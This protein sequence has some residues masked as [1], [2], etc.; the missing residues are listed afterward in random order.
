MNRKIIISLALIISAAL[1][2]HFELLIEKRFIS[3]L[4]TVF[5][6]F[7]GFYLTSFA[8]FSTSKYLSKL[9]EIEDKNDNRMT[10][11]DRVIEKFKWPT[12]FL[13]FSFVYLILVY[14]IL[15]NEVISFVYYLSYAL[16]GIVFLNIFFVTETISTFIKITR[17]SAKL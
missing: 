2:W 1:Q 3:S 4:L 10:L 15:A 13:L 7:F 11:L 5:S 8:V 9:Y 17:Q 6:I 14:V 12:Y 16:W